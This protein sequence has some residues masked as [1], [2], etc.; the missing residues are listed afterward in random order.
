LIWKAFA[1][2]GLGYSAAQGNPN[3]T[4]DGEEAFDLPPQTNAVESLMTQWVRVF[5]NPSQ[6]WVRIEPQDVHRLDAVQLFDAQGREILVGKH[7]HVGGALTL[8]LR[9]LPAGMYNLSVQSGTLTSRF[10]LIHR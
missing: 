4:A 5:P 2:R 9:E 7:V 1:R 6:D 10:A 8:D 3:N